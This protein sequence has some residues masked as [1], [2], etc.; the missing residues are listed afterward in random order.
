M[1]KLKESILNDTKKSSKDT[2]N[3]GI[4]AGDATNGTTT[5]TTGATTRLNDAY[6]CGVGI[7][8]LLATGA[9]VFFCI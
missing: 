3:A 1:N 4:D 9:C 8:A 7:I 2:S 5:S 6:I